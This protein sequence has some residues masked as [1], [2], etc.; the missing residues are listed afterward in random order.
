[1]LHPL[2]VI[3]RGTFRIYGVGYAV[4]FEHVIEGLL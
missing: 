3:L 4:W 2:V 1:V